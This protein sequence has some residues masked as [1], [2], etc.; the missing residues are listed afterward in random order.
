MSPLGII[1]LGMPRCYVL[2]LISANFCGD[3]SSIDT[4]DKP[5]GREGGK[6]LAPGKDT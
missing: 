2:A 6:Q 5:S 1:G 4:T 3:K